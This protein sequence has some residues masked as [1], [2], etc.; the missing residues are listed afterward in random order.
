L[1]IAA[2][3]GFQSVLEEYSMAAYHLQIAVHLQP[4]RQCWL[5]RT[6]E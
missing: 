5:I 6:K 3:A 2:I 1:K 4:S